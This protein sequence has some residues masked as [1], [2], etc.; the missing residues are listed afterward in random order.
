M[1]P[2]GRIPVRDRIR[3]ISGRRPQI[4]RGAVVE[5]IQMLERKPAVVVYSED[6]GIIRYVMKPMYVYLAG[7]D[8]V[9]ESNQIS[10]KRPHKFER[11]GRA[12]VQFQPHYLHMV[13]SSDYRHW[14]E[15]EA[16]LNLDGFARLREKEDA[17]ILQYDP[18]RNNRR[19]GGGTQ[20]EWVRHWLRELGYASMREFEGER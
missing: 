13:G 17:L 4:R 19:G 5:N 11:M 14:S 8:I 18:P 1:N 12:E 20:P 16:I 3:N 2:A 7:N 15:D 6:A 9:A 10:T